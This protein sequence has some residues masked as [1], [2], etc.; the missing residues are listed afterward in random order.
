MVSVSCVSV[1]AGCLACIFAQCII[2][3]PRP[4][5]SVSFGKCERARSDRNWIWHAR[6]NRCNSCHVVFLIHTSTLLLWYSLGLQYQQLYLF[7]L[8]VA[9]IDCGGCCCCQN[10]YC[11]DNI[12]TSF[13]RNV[14]SS[15]SSSTEI[16]RGILFSKDTCLSQ[17]KQQLDCCIVGSLLHLRPVIEV[18]CLCNSWDMDALESS[19]TIATKIKGEYL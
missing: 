17:A 14:S 7:G 19:R 13:K 16:A 15:S 12:H 4:P 8:F 18:N 6:S 2:R 1:G 9:A 10:S 3:D 11:R 5:V